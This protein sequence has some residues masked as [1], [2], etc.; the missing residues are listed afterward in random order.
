MAQEVDS[1][2]RSNEPMKKKLTIDNLI[3]DNVD[4]MG[5]INPSAMES[6]VQES[7]SE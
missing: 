7:Q 3:Q 2:S 5:T 4:Q 1:N 6:P